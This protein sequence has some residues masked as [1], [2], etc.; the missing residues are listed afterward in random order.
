MRS[1]PAEPLQG[2]EQHLGASPWLLWVC[3]DEERGAG[4]VSQRAVN[5]PLQVWKQ[6][7]CWLGSLPGLLHPAFP[8]ADNRRC[9]CTPQEGKL[10]LHQHLSQGKV[11]SAHT[12]HQ[13]LWDVKRVFGTPSACKTGMGMG[14]R[15]P[16]QPHWSSTKAVPL[17]PWLRGP[18][19]PL[20]EAMDHHSKQRDNGEM[21]HKRGRA[22]AT[23]LCKT[24]PLPHLH[25]LLSPGGHRSVGTRT[26]QVPGR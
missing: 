7:E 9:S 13:S 25:T 21:G 10:G 23:L 2:W 4:W 22:A 15:P 19:L 18:Q 26:V 24:S 14:Q 5:K 1:F 6:R 17:Q 11:G 16:E 3:L 12:E 20:E 8:S